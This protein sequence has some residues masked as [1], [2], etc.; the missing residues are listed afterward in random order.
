MSYCTACGYFSKSPRW[1]RG[2]CPYCG[3]PVPPK[4]WGTVFNS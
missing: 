4:P 2:H 1:K 3:S